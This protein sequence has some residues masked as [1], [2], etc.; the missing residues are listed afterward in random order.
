M[1]VTDRTDRMDIHRNTDTTDIPDMT[2][3]SSRTAIT[4]VRVASVGRVAIKEAKRYRRGA[5][6]ALAGREYLR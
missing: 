3:L 6:E 5:E 2:L 4:H 1:S